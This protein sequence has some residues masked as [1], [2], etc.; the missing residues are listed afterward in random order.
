MAIQAATLSE[1][2]IFYWGEATGSFVVPSIPKA[3]PGVWVSWVL[4]DRKELVPGS[5][6]SIGFVSTIDSSK[7]EAGFDQGVNALRMTGYQGVI[8]P[9]K[10]LDAQTIL[11]W[12]G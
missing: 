12:N 7:I 11:S 10:D 6:G 5:F 8:P 4:K 1:Q 3:N 9:F 2:Y